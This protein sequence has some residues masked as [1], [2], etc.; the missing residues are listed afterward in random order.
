MISSCPRCGGVLA[1]EHDGFE[2]YYNC[3]GCAR[4]FDTD[5]QARRMNPK[6]LKN[7]HGIYLQN[8]KQCVNLR[9]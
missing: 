6:E 9:V 1:K 3:L 4:E 5:L 7:R 8:A 2:T